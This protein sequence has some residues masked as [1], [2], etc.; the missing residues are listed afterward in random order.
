MKKYVIT[1]GIF[2]VFVLYI[3]Y[4]SLSGPSLYILE[5]VAY[6]D[7]LQ[8][9]QMRAE[10]GDYIVFMFFDPADEDSP[11]VNMQ[12]S[13]NDQGVPGLEWLLI[14]DKNISD[15]DKVTDLFVAAGYGYDLYNVSD[16]ELLRVENGD[17]VRLGKQIIYELYNIDDSDRVEVLIQGYSTKFLDKE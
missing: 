7:V 17:I 1:T 9:F 10:P 8:E 12:Y 5:K 11:A 16:V 15:R 14:G 13:V 4:R 3:L 6:N 2:A